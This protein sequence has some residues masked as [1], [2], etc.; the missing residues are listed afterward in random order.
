MNSNLSRDADELRNYFDIS[1]QKKNRDNSLKESEKAYQSGTAVILSVVGRNYPIDIF[2][3]S[4]IAFNK[5]KLILM[6]N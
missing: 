1:K 2:Y 5:K 6:V 4:G 3:S